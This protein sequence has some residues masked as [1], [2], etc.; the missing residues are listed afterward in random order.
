MA[1]K[2]NDSKASSKP[3]KGEEQAENRN[4]EV[5]ENDNIEIEIE[6]ETDGD[7]EDNVHEGPWGD[8]GVFGPDGPF[9]HKGPFGPT[10]PF[11]PGGLFGP[12]GLFGQR[13]KRHRHRGRVHM[14]PGGPRGSGRR[15]RMFG[16]GELRL[17]LLALITEE[18]RHGYDCIK[19]LEEATGGAYAPSPG[20]VYP[21]LQMLL[22]EGM[23]VEQASED[24]RKVY[25]ATDAGKAELE[26]RKDEIEELLER[27]GRRAKRANA[28]KSSDMMR[29]MGNLA[30]VLAN[31]AKRGGFDSDS[32]EKIVD[33]ID[34]L[35]R[36]VE[37]L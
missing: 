4:E 20:V 24:S 19:A 3:G 32:R 30:S 9:G 11:G 26:E 23:I 13:G 22:D 34:E 15:G 21:T 36:K 28:A 18:P 7:D 16:S 1:R 33:L 2:K 17:V 12:Q 31:R 29:A 25:E 27:L 6:I 5:H 10:G 35:A 8:K 37:R 14:G